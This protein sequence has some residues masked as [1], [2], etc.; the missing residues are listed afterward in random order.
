MTFSRN[1]VLRLFH[2]GGPGRHKP[3]SRLFGFDRGEPVDRYYIRKALSRYSNDVR[4]QVLEIG[5]ARYTNEL[6]GESVKRVEILHAEAD[7]AAATMV[8]D[9]S[10]GEGIPEDVFDCIILT[11]TL[12]VIYDV[13]SA[14]MNVYKALKPGGVVLATFPG[15]TQ[16]SRYDMDR[17]GDYWRFTSLSARR[18]FEDVFGD[19]VHVEAFGNV[20]VATAF[21]YGFCAEEL[22]QKEL[23]YIDPDYEVL[24]AVRARKPGG[25]S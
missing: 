7:N 17:W 3:V 6:G 1:M 14:I 4:G 25:E 5:E 8:G 22:T 20:S 24:L 11:Q 23:D 16:I 2:L 15:I 21:L 10:T 12:N 9:L 19:D 18:L 13:K